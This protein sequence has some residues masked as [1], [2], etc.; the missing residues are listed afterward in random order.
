MLWWGNCTLDRF[1]SCVPVALHDE[2]TCPEQV[3][4]CTTNV[5]RFAGS[6]AP[7]KR[8][9]FFPFLQIQMFS[10]SLVLREAFV[11]PRF[12][13]FVQC[14]CYVQYIGATSEIERQ[15]SFGP[16]QICSFL[17]NKFLCPLAFMWS[18][19][20]SWASEDRISLVSCGKE[21]LPGETIP[22]VQAHSWTG[23]RSRDSFFYFP[24]RQLHNAFVSFKHSFEQLKRW[25]TFSN[26]FFIPFF[27][28]FY[29]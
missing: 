24:T 16:H 22:L 4:H 7:R 17:V 27:D 14:L 25:R 18:K 12:P 9:L 21:R 19:M 13:S 29:F 6:I 8:W 23:L 26:S 15:S 5:Q 3:W 11:G 28:L 20:C 10:L 1:S 2:R